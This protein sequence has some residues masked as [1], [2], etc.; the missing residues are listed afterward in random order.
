M[1]VLDEVS[2]GSRY[3]LVDIPLLVEYL[4]C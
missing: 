2:I 4:S 1:G 3:L